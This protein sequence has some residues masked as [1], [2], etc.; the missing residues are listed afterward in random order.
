L[1]ALGVY[2]NNTQDYTWVVDPS[3]GQWVSKGVSDWLSL[4]QAEVAY[5]IT[6]N[7]AI[8]HDF[9]LLT[10]ATRASLSARASSSTILWSETAIGYQL[11]KQ[12]RVMA[13][14]ENDAVFDSQNAVSM[15]QQKDMLYN[16]YFKLSI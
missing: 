4:Y 10:K 1:L 11:M 6:D 9:Y 2:Y 15:Y 14:V 13:S 16:L 7:L 5:N 8:S 12:L 3:S